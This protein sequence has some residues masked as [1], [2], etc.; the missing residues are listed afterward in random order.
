MNTLK[1]K[2]SRLYI[3]AFLMLISVSVVLPIFFY[4]SKVTKN[5]ERFDVIKRNYLA[6][7][8]RV[9]D[10]SPEILPLVKVGDIQ[11]DYNGEENIKIESIIKVVPQ[12]TGRISISGTD[13]VD[14]VSA[15]KDMY[16]RLKIRYNMV[17]DKLALHPTMIILKIGK[18]LV[19]EF[20]DYCLDG[21]I[22]KIYK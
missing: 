7:E 3:P 17:D 18:K 13:Y 10:I 15:K 21:E 20:E 14:M 16:V 5:P 4:L 9:S 19:F 2:V 12:I 11:K 22:I 6:M 8:I 1:G